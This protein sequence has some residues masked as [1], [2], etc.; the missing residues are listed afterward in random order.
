MQALRSITNFIKEAR[1]IDLDGYR[2]SFL[3]RRLSKRIAD[4]HNAEVGAKP[5]EPTGNIFY[6]KIPI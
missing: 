3:E 5:N 4:A 6:I 1:G 2:P